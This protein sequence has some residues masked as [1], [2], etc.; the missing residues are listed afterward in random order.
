MFA[1]CKDCGSH[2]PSDDVC[3]SCD[4][5]ARKAVV[6]ALGRV[7]PHPTR[8]ALAFGEA[9]GR[10][11][12]VPAALAQDG[13]VGL[14]LPPG[15]VLPAAFLADLGVTGEVWV[16]GAM[17]GG[18]YSEGL[19][20]PSVRATAGGVLAPAAGWQAKWKVGQ[21]VSRAAGVCFAHLPAREDRRPG[22]PDWPNVSFLG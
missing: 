12:V 16:A 11:V 3:Q 2:I 5:L 6:A 21:E 10:Q 1:I 7:R 14:F 4:P 8:P 22:P 18:V 15:A 9:A 19:F 17:V 20:Y 13:L